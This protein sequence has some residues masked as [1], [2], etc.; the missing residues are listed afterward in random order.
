VNQTISQ[1]RYT[2]QSLNNGWANATV[3]FDGN[4]V[5][6][7]ASIDLALVGLGS[8]VYRVTRTDGTRTD[9]FT[10]NTTVLPSYSF[11][12]LGPAATVNPACR[13]RFRNNAPDDIDV[14]ISATPSLAGLETITLN[15][16]Q[17][18]PAGGYVDLLMDFY[19]S[20]GYVVASDGPQPI[21]T[22]FARTRDASGDIMA[23]ASVGTEIHSAPAL[24]PWASL[25][26]ALGL[27]VTG[28]AFVAMRPQGEAGA[29]SL[30]SR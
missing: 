1:T 11:E 6:A 9:T 15:N 2:H 21:G 3:T 4:V 29:K 8:H 12:V 14:D 25:I 26:A 30:T 13:V 10:F 22:L 18:V 20:S 5:P 23:S 7:N 27:L 17:L 19:T 24:S 28:W 16:R